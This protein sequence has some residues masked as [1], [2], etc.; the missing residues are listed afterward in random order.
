MVVFTWQKKYTD[1]YL[2]KSWDEIS[3]KLIKFTP[4][5]KT[6]NL[7]KIKFRPMIMEQ[8]DIMFLIG[9]LFTTQKK[10]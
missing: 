3:K 9:K 10:M 4:K 2:G 1:L 5:I 6:K 7:K 8:G